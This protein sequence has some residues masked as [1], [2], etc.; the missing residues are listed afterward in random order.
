MGAKIKPPL[1]TLVLVSLVLSIFALGC[2]RPATAPIPEEINPPSS[3]PGQ[4]KP[5]LPASVNTSS[6]NESVYPWDPGP[7]P[8][9]SL[10]PY[11]GPPKLDPYLWGLNQAEKRGELVDGQVKVKI[12]C[13]P[14]LM[15]WAARAVNSAGGKVVGSSIQYHWLFALVPISG[16]DTLAKARSIRNIRQPVMPYAPSPPTRN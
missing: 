5:P 12:D 11:T 10:P 13:V 6:D 7:T 9:P 8:P 4:E 3:A 14:V 1:V 2:A 16:L 15:W